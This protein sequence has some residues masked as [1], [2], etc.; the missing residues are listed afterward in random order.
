MVDTRRYESLRSPPR[1]A[2]AF[3]LVTVV[4]DIVALGVVIP[5]LPQLV[6]EF[7]GSAARAAGSTACSWPSGP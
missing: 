5:V 2:L 1:A 7:T 6:E 3:I 4:I